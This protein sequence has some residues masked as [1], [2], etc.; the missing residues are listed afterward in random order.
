M[1]KIEALFDP[2]YAFCGKTHFSVIKGISIF[3]VVLVHLCN[4]YSNFTYLSPFA[5]AAVAVFLLCSG[6]GLSESLEKKQGLPNYWSNKIVKIWLPSFLKLSFFCLIT[7]SGLNSWLTEYPL[8][9]YGWYLQ[10]LFAE[11]LVFWLLFRFIKNRKFCLVLL[12]AAS[13]VAYGLIQDQLYA[14]QLF[15]FP[16]G[17]AFSQLKWKDAME[18]WGWFRKMLLT[19]ICFVLAAGAFVMRNRFSHYLLFNG[20]WMLFKLSLAVLICFLPYYL[21]K[22]RLFGLFIPLGSISY[23][24]YLINNDILALLEGNM[25]WY[26]VAGVILLLLVSAVLFKLICD[27]LSQLYDKTIGKKIAAG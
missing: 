7:W 16:F 2:S 11:Y 18:K 13:I 17:V 14:E 6:Y 23:M 12:F 10:V 26:T 4:R 5:G 27:K 3:V 22:I 19:G 1:K 9:L 20:M 24:L 25:Y 15:C 8:F 21:R